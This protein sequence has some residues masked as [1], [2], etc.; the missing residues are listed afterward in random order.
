MLSTSLCPCRAALAVFLLAGFASA[1]MSGTYTIDANGTGSRN[2][3]DIQNAAYQL[4][5]QGVNGAVVL[6]VASGTHSS[7]RPFYLAPV[8]GASSKNT[9]TFRSKTRH[10]ANLTTYFIMPDY[11]PSFPIRW[12]VFDGLMFTTLSA[13]SGTAISGNFHTTD[14]EIKNCRFT[15]TVVGGGASRTS[16]KPLERWNVHHNVFEGNVSSGNC[17]FAYVHAIHIHHN[18]FNLNNRGGVAISFISHNQSSVRSRI[19]NNGIPWHTHQ[20]NSCKAKS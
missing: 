4:F 20:S 1:Q 2:F 5:V 3:K 12:Y 10:G 18:E 11:G 16:S 9:I 13:T 17:Y 7:T 15:K 14:I 19:Y 6:E 8:K